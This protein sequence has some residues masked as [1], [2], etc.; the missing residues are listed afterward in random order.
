M[1]HGVPFVSALKEALCMLPSRKE[2]EHDHSYQ[3]GYGNG[4]GG[5][6]KGRGKC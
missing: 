3:I 6:G 1:I 2:G 4:V 5:K